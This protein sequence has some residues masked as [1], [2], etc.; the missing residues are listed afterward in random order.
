MSRS[1]VRPT[2]IFPA[3]E[4]CLFG[5]YS[6]PVPLRVGDRV[7]LSGRLDLTRWYIRERSVVPTS[8]RIRCIVADISRSALCCHSNENRAPISNPP[9]SPQLEG[10]LYH[11]PK[12]HPGPCSSVR[13]RRETDRKTHAQTAV[14]TI[15]FAFST[16]HGKCNQ[17]DYN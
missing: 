10:T 17:R 7:G 11:Y 15:H 16:A 4:H 6:L 5:R 9:N 3:E 2:V 12:L 8:T 13:M 14:A 1:E